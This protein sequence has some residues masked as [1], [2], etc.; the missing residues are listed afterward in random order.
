L[1]PVSEIVGVVRDSKY[2]SLREEIL[3]TAFVA[4]NQGTTPT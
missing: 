4:A 2:G 1:T 3:P